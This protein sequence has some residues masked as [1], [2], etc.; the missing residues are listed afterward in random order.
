MS[1]RPRSPFRARLLLAGTLLAATAACGWEL[2]P[3]EGDA[4]RASAERPAFAPAGSA[5]GARPA[6]YGE[7]AADDAPAPRPVADGPAGEERLP[8]ALPSGPVVRPLPDG[9]RPDTIGVLMPRRVERRVAGIDVDDYLLWLPPGL[10]KGDRRWPLLLWLHGRSL[11]GDDLG[12]LERYGPPL[13][14][15]RGRSLPFVVVAPQLPAGGRWA[16]L[17]PVAEIVEEVAER[18]PVD[19]DRIYLMGYSMGGG[20]AYR[21]AF[22]HA[23]RFAAMI[24][25][26]GHTP[27][28][29]PENVRAVASVPF[30]AIHGADDVRVPLAP[31]KRM[32]AALAA[33]GAPFFEFRVTPGANHARLERLTRDDALYEWL[34][35]HRRPRVAGGGAATR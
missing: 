13:L 3:R 19:R 29:T 17:D 34:L 2:G 7:D 16:D 10:E 32:A 25:I 26:A 9:A 23:D 8:P 15:S 35:A 11:R 30:L 27:P 33:T 14:L 1:D 6:R 28:A 20:G 4:P 22:S 12:R 24:G 31:A 5:F 18:Y 21:M